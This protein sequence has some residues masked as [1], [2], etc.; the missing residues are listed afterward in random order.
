MCAMIGA[1][2]KRLIVLRHAKSAW[3]TDAPDDHS[4]PL[5]KRGRKDAPLI[6]ARLAQLE[7]VPQAVISSDSARTRETWARM[8]E[9]LLGDDE[10]AEVHFTR[11]LFHADEREI[12]AALA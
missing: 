6:G 5:A 4:R 3:D 7:W 8:E 9:A 1:M 12:R 2:T 10:E 11:D